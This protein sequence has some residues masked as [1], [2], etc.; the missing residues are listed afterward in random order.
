MMYTFMSMTSKKFDLELK[1]DQTLND[2]K[3]QLEKITQQKVMAFYAMGRKCK[4]QDSLNEYKNAPYIVVQF[5]PQK[6]PLDE[7][8]KEPL[9]NSLCVIC[10]SGIIDTVLVP[11]GHLGMCFSCAFKCEQCPMC[12]NHIDL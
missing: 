2:A 11:C 4:L 3:D 6:M 10:E 12:R 5:S 7:E 9:F 8:S 1:D